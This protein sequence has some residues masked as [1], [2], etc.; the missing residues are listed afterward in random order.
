MKFT[1]FHVPLPPNPKHVGTTYLKSENQTL[2]HRNAVK[3]SAATRSRAQAEE[4]AGATSAEGRRGSKV[5][6]IHPGSR[7]LRIGRASD[8][9]P[10]SV[11][12]VIARKHQP[13]PAPAFVEGISRPRKDRERGEVSTVVQPGDEYSVGLASDD[14]FD[15]KVA[16]IQVSLRDRMRFYKLRVTT[17]AAATASQFNEQFKP[18]TIPEANDP[19]RVDWIKAPS[20]E[21][22]VVGDAAL[23]LSDPAEL[24]YVLRW[25]LYGGNFNTRNYNSTEEILGDIETIITA[26]LDE[27][28]NVAPKSYKEHSVV[29]VIPDFYD[30]SYVQRMV[31]MLLVTMGFKQLCVQQES[32][33]ATY[34][35]GISNGCVV[36]MGATTTSIACVDDGLVISDTRIV[37]N[38]AGNDITEFLYVLLQKIN[39]PYRD[40]DLARSYDWNVIEDLK[41]RLC[42][43]AEGDVALNLYD[44]VVRRPGKSTEKYGLRA[45]DEIILAPMCLF[46]PRVI[47]FEQKRTGTRPYAS[48]EVT[49]EILEQAADH[50]T[51][52]M[53]I[54]TQHLLPSALPTPIVLQ[55]VPPAM[56]TTGLNTPAASEPQAEATNDASSGAASGPPED[57]MEATPGADAG[58]EPKAE[59]D[60]AKADSTSTADGAAE[61]IDV[62]EAEL[63]AAAVPAGSSVPPAAA[64]HQQQQQ[65]AAGTPAAATY[66]GGYTI[67]VCFE[68][69]KLPLD[70]A[71]FNS[72][73]AA[74]GD[75]KIR[76]YLQA[77]LVVGGCALVPGMG[78]ALE[79]RL[80]AI[81]TPLVQSMEKVQIIPPPKDVDPRALAWKGAAVLGKM[82]GVADLWITSQD[83]DILGMRGLKERC[84]YL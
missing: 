23:R 39:F 66:P 77:V 59:P 65:A 30:R 31:R 51:Q 17:N 55:E 34:G 14:P 64:G 11:P 22:Y 48:L 57:A 6:V 13:V 29:L 80:Q 78:H 28:F 10:A 58:E 56:Q 47:E 16:A 69:S 21:A 15:A 54:S 71:I 61:V 40:L 2:W 24:G 18:E 81:A 12:N 1:S 74:G 49:D 26:V 79:S 25:P 37:L 82:D 68:A 63:D 9:T 73:R 72:A 83:W 38:M 20:D 7:F 32:L 70:V 8:V 76:K 5:I 53:I 44:F 52:A 19:F 33:A 42:T 35:A 45:Y 43:L 75:E 36:D 67:D 46:E 3:A 41:A 84:F 27:K 50:F 4:L 62:D 60:L